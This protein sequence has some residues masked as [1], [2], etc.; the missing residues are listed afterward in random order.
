MLTSFHMYTF[1]RVGIWD[2]HR[3][4]SF[5]YVKIIIETMLYAP[6]EH[7][8]GKLEMCRGPAH[9]D[10]SNLK[11]LIQLTVHGLYDFQICK[12]K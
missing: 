7:L 1:S 9:P 10:N 3:R 4:G 5:A 11:L 6:R 8:L 12:N 2:N